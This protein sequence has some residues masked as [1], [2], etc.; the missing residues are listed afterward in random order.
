M[1][2]GGTESVSNRYVVE[3]AM[4][5]LFLSELLAPVRVY[6][7]ACRKA[8]LN[9]HSRQCFYTTLPLNNH[10]D[11]ELR[12]ICTDVFISLTSREQE[13]TCFAFTSPAVGRHDNELRWILINNEG[14]EFCLVDTDGNTH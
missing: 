11:L 1:A 4:V 14:A 5:G 9:H 6:V 13:R 3:V 8:V 2:A 12:L 10:H 7:C